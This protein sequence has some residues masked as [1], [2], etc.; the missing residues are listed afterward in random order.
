MRLAAMQ[1]AFGDY[2]G[3]GVV[4]TVGILVAL[5]PLSLW[6]ADFGALILVAIG[7]AIICVG[8]LSLRDFTRNEKEKT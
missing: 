7:T 3:Y 1:S 2:L 6:I 8:I 4:I 5:M